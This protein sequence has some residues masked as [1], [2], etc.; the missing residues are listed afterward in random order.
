MEPSPT[1]PSKALVDKE[2][3]SR[4]PLFLLF[5]LWLGYFFF[6]LLLTSYQARLSA[7]VL[8]WA[9][10]LIWTVDRSWTRFVPIIA[11]IAVIVSV[12]MPFQFLAMMVAIALASAFVLSWAMLLIGEDLKHALRDGFWLAGLLA[13]AM[14][15]IAWFLLDNREFGGDVA[16]LGNTCPLPVALLLG[17]LASCFGSNAW[18]RMDTAGFTF[19]QQ[20]LTFAAV[21]WLGFSCGW[22]VEIF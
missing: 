15:L 10:A 5:L 14:F 7:W 8:A 2:F 6:G 16:V 21:T 20:I 18:M 3:Y 11:A 17:F 13:I 19:K 22:L 12:S 9:G 1:K 4:L